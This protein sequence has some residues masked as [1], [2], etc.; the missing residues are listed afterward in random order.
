MRAAERREEEP[1][2]EAQLGDDARR[3]AARGGAGQ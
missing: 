1:G 3:G 2:N